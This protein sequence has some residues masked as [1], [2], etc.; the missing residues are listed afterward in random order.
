MEKNKNYIDVQ[1][2]K[3]LIE[4]NNVNP[5][6]RFD[7]MLNDYDAEY[8]RISRLILLALYIIDEVIKENSDCDYYCY[9]QDDSSVY[10][11]LSQVVKKEILD[12]YFDK[13]VFF[14]DFA[15]LVYRFTCAKKF[16]IENDLI[17]QLRINSWGRE[18]IV[19]KKVLMGYANEYKKM[20]TYMIGY[21]SRNKEIYDTLIQLLKNYNAKNA[22]KVSSLNKDVK[23]KILS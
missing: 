6:E 21:Y 10:Y 3:A 22:K 7:V 13:C 11:L 1:N 17:N 23:V 18:Y 12:E 15:K 20:K 19:E 8:T 4:L 14:V 5:I 16:D 9:I 2:N